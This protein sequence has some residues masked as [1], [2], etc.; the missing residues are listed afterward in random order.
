MNDTITAIATPP[1]EGGLS[2]I[3]ISGEDALFI[4]LRLFHPAIGEKV[5]E[6]APQKVLF[7]EIRDPG[8][9]QCVDEVLLTFLKDREVIPP[10][11]SSRSVPTA[12]HG[13]PQEY[14]NWF[15]RKGPG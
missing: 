10:K 1:G 4:A 13:S 8:K 11:M 3:R 12:G 9:G 2:I 7:G 14:S 15:W 5:K 6:L